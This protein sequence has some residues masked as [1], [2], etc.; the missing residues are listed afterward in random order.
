MSLEEYTDWG[1]TGLMRPSVM[2]TDS[3]TENVNDKA[4]FQRVTTYHLRDWDD[5]R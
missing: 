5:V 3:G 4:R 1:T 2:G